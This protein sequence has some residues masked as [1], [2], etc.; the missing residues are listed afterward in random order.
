MINFTNY[1]YE[2]GLATI[3]SSEPI[4]VI[5]QSFNPIDLVIIWFMLYICVIFVHEIG[6]LYAL[7]AQGKDAT[8]Y[9]GLK[10]IWPTFT[11]GK[12]EDYRTMSPRQRIN[13][14]A[15]GI[16]AGAIPIL[17]AMTIHPYFMFM[18]IIYMFGIMSDYDG[19]IRDWKLAR[20]EK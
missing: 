15:A 3:K 20:L 2:I 10:G 14:Y 19:I 12:E 6:H 5:V 9:V 7:R 13:V 1:T 8:L 4:N 11:A 16:G 17:A 18:W